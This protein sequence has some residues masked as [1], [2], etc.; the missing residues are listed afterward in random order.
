MSEPVLSQGEILRRLSAAAQEARRQHS[1]ASALIL[2]HRKTRNR[3]ASA[4]LRRSSARR[5]AARLLRWW[6][7]NTQTQLGRRC[8]ARARE[9]LL[10]RR[11]RARRLSEALRLWAARAAHG[12]RRRLLPLRAT[13]YARERL[14]VRSWSAWMHFWTS[15]AQQ[16][17]DLAQKRRQLLRSRLPVAWRFW[18][19]WAQSSSNSSRCFE[20]FRTKCRKTLRQ[21]TWV[22]W[23]RFLARRWARQQRQRE[24][25]ALF[26]GASRRHALVELW[27]AM[28]LRQRRAEEQL[29]EQ[30][31]WRRASQKEAFQ[32]MQAWQM[33]S[34]R[35]KAAA[36]SEL[37]N[38]RTKLR[39]ERETATNDTQKRHLGVC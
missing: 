20:L 39:M 37:Q 13:C 6:H 7:H 4:W 1:L 25:M 27:E 5:G 24:A 32:V 36:S 28:A 14:L 22:A 26:K 11:C 19:T 33:C 10:Q 31:R 2:W 38:F 29:V 23:H 3:R 16:A 30:W 34:A 15:C 21:R 17:Q 18:H 12:A 35:T 8:A 9:A